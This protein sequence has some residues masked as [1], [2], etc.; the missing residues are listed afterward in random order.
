MAAYRRKRHF[1]QCRPACSPHTADKLEDWLLL[2]AN[3]E[4]IDTCPA[5][6]S[7]YFAWPEV[8]YVP[9]V[10]AEPS[11]LAIVRRRD[12]E[13][14]LVASLIELAVDIAGAVS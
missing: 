6:I 2:I 3:G 9:L 1:S 11:T 14:P 4:G 12:R 10:D 5:V 13:D 7:R 8:T